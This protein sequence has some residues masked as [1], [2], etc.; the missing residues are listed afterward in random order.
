MSG[1]TNVGSIVWVKPEH[2]LVADETE[3]IADVYMSKLGWDYSTDLCFDT[4]GA[5]KC[6]EP[7]TG[8]EGLMFINE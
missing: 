3:K 2:E 7:E 4:H 1:W 8:K 6:E 5:D